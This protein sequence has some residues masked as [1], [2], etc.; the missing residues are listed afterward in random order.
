MR[1]IG[2]LIPFAHRNFL[3][4][5]MFKFHLGRELD[6]RTRPFFSFLKAFFRGAKRRQRLSLRRARR[7]SLT[8]APDLLF[9]CSCVLYQAKIRAVLQ[10]IGGFNRYFPLHSPFSHFIPNHCCISHNNRPR[11]LC[12]VCP[13][14]YVPCMPAC[15]YTL[16]L[17]NTK[18][19]ILQLKQQQKFVAY[20][21]RNFKTFQS[22]SK[23]CV[24]T[25]CIR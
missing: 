19:P 20:L 6:C 7:A 18:C 14:T 16:Y 4:G 12:P 17:I 9:D 24:P 10:S 1:R 11:F 25:S 21:S 2:R 13:Y 22:C 5:P 15:L 3:F 8:L 23:F